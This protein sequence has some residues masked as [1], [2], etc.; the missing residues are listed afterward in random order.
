MAPPPS[1]TAGRD[2][3]LLRPD[4]IAQSVA[5]NP[6]PSPARPARSPHAFNRVS[7]SPPSHLLPSRRLSRPATSPPSQNLPNVRLQALPPGHLM[8][9]VTPT[10]I[11]PALWRRMCSRR[12]LQPRTVYLTLN[13]PAAL[14]PAHLPAALP[15]G[16]LTPSV[17]AA[18]PPGHLTLNVSSRPFSVGGMRST[19]GSSR[20]SLTSLP[21]TAQGWPSR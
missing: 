10:S 16:H 18:L 1:R 19:M 2:P 12:F 15:P 20:R 17:P 14:P 7:P 5:L 9:N 4:A 11:L 6:Q 21:S 13:V 3:K 8:L